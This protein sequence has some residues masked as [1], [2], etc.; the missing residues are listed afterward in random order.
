VAARIE[1]H[2]GD[3]ASN[4]TRSS[5]DTDVAA[6]GKHTAAAMKDAVDATRKTRGDRL[7]PTREIPRASRFDDH[8]HVVA[9]DRVVNETKSTPLARRAPAS[10]QLRD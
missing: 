5:Q 7:Q 8:V 9:L 3:R 6:I 1:K 2:I 10:L 4:L